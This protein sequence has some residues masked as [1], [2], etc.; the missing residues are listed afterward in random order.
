MEGLIPPWLQ[1]MLLAVLTV[2]IGLDRLARRSPGVAWLQPFRLPVLDSRRK[3][4]DQPVLPSVRC[5][6]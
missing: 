2:I 6:S 3:E 5:C 4:E 1:V